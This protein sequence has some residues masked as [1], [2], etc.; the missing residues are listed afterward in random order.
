M[1][2]ERLRETLKRDEGFDLRRHEVQGID[3][4]GY[5]INLEQELPDELLE[6]LGVEAED[7]IQE[8]TQEQA[9][10][11]L[12]YYVGIAEGDCIT[13]FGDQWCQLSDLR[14]EVLIN[15]AFNLG[16]P[17]LKAFRKMIV[18]I[19]EEDWTEAAAQMLDS[20]AARQTGKR[21]QRLARTFEMNDESYLKLDKIYDEPTVRQDLP[22]IPTEEE[23]AGV[24][25][26]I[27]IAELARRLGL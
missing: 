25:D 11:L 8:I 2:I 27:L 12:D 26:H 20:K 16:L 13:I 23:L 19:R 1:I 21:Y 6:Y 14:Q 24:E 7:T 3:H 22:V 18:A 5:G 4:I 10:Y 9:D 15:L 17:R